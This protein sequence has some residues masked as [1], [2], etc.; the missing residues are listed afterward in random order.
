MPAH[1]LGGLR[2][3]SA[4]EQVSMLR[5]VIQAGSA[6]PHWNL[7]A[8]LG[9]GAGERHIRTLTS[10]VATAEHTYWAVRAGLS[11]ISRPGSVSSSS[12]T[13]SR[14]LTKSEK[15]R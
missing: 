7:A 14:D 2:V 15:E 5:G 12:A 9:C 11:R 3:A 13:A 10:L 8:H 1:W 6:W 4:G